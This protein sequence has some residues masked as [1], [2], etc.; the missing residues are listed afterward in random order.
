MGIM[1]IFAQ[2]E[3]ESAARHGKPEWLIVGLGNP[4]M[5]YEN[6]RHNAGFLAIDAL[7]AEEN[8]KIDRLRF[9]G[10]T[11]DVT[12]G[13]QRCLLLKPQT[14]MN[15]SGEAVVQALQFYK[16]DTDHLL[17]MFDD[18]SLAPGKL[19]IRRKGSAGGHNGIKSIIELTGSEDFARI[20]IGVGAKPRKEMDLADWVLSKFRPEEKEP[21]QE[22]CKKAAACLRLMVEGKTTEAMNQYNS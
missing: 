14:Y 11:G 8:V 17:V 13:E 1:D 22:A 21:M 15:N 9:K 7:A 12:L 10:Y 2:L 16:L 18:I 5:Q 3:K 6:T 4:G 19:R 20:K